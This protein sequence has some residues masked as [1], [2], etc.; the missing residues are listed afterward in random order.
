MVEYVKLEEKEIEK[1][2][3]LEKRRVPKEKGIYGNRVLSIQQIKKA[4]AGSSLMPKKQTL[5]VIHSS[6]PS[7]A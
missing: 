3:V 1:N 2:F 7:G 5:S 4:S 6:I